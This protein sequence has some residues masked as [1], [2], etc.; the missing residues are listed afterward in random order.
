MLIIYFILG[1][2]YLNSILFFVKF[3]LLLIIYALM[4]FKKYPLNYPFI[5]IDLFYL[6]AFLHYKYFSFFYDY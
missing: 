6:S 3:Y 2:F 1:I 5:L 4:L